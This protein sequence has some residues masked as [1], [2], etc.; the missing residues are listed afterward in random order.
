MEEPSYF[1]NAHNCAQRCSLP[2]T[3]P[4]RHADVSEGQCAEALSI[5]ELFLYN[6][7]VRSLRRKYGLGRGKRLTQHLLGSE[8]VLYLP[9]H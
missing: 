8:Y 4:L 7:S 6:E 3:C 1:L 9:R 2:T 5:F